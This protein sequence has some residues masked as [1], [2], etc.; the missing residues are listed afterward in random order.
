MGCGDAGDSVAG[1]IMGCGDAGDS[2]AGAIMGCGGAGDSVAGAIMGCGNAGDS[3]AGAIM[4]CGDAGDT[5][6]EASGADDGL[7]HHTNRS[8]TNTPS[9]SA[10]IVCSPD[11]VGGMH[12]IPFFLFEIRRIVLLLRTH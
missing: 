8:K 12:S 11:T 10:A 3:V 9:P 4:A 6:A 5:V 7:P 2:V 1:A